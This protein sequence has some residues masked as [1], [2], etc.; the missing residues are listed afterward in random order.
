MLVR[1]VKGFPVKNLDGRLIGTK[2]QLANGREVWALVGNVDAQRPTQNEHFLTL[3]IEH[4]GK[5]FDLARYH[6]IDFANRG[7]AALSKFLGLQVDEVFPISVDLRPFAEG[8]PAALANVIGKE[9]RE[10]LSE[11]ELIALS[12]Q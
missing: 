4:A 1:P 3:S 5:W 6:D 11:A 10:R 2:V 8:I 12:L 9:P 7:P